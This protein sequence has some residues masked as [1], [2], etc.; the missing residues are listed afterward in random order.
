VE[1]FKMLVYIGGRSVES[2]EWLRSNL[3][4]IGRIDPEI[5]AIELD[6]N[7][8]EH[9]KDSRR[10]DVG[11]DFGSLGHCIGRNKSINAIYICHHNLFDPQ[12]EVNRDCPVSGIPARE[13][14]ILF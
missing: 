4:Y 7:N 8:I 6:V 13:W 5:Q 2:V 3:E 10:A 9:A 11:N 1:R 12:N 14:E